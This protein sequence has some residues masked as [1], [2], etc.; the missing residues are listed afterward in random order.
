MQPDRRAVEIFA[1]GESFNI[2]D[3]KRPSMCFLP[4]RI[5]GTEARVL[6]IDLK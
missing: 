6:F 3:L 4:Y 5:Y 1:I 2:Y